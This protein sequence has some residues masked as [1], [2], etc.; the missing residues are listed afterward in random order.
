MKITLTKALGGHDK[1][2]TIDVPDAIAQRLIKREVATSDGDSDTASDDGYP[3]GEP[4]E[5][6]SAKQ[7]DAYANDHDIDLTGATKKA[8]KAARILEV[9]TAP[10][11]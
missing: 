3:E 9:I 4:T 7:L 2:D 1:G 8:D 10:Q 11:A 6:W 5:K